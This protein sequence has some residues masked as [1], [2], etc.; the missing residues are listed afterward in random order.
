MN[1]YEKYAQEFFS[2]MVAMG[3]LMPP[4]AERITRGEM[5]MV[6]ILDHE[7]RSLSAGELSKI[8]GLCTGRTTAI[9]ISLEE[10]GYIQRAH[11]KKDHRIVMVSLS[12][13]GRASV[14]AGK[15]DMTEKAAAFFEKLGA[16]DTQ[17]LLRI[18]RKASELKKN[19][20]ASENPFLD[21]GGPLP[22]FDAKKGN[23]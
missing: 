23:L 1:T 21:D 15:E 3:P 4:V 2:L 12:K 17:D 5:R 13:K 7:G 14:E 9:L 18:I 22:P 19:V 8:T 6:M 16:D 10:K 11:S 20:P